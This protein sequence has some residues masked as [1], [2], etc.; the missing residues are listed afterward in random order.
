[1]QRFSPISSVHGPRKTVWLLLI[2]LITYLGQSAQIAGAAETG[3]PTPI[4]NDLAVND[5]VALNQMANDLVADDP[6]AQR[7]DALEQN[8]TRLSDDYRSLQND[9]DDLK[10]SM[11]RFVHPGHGDATMKVGGRIHLDYWAFPASSPGI[12][13]IATAGL[14]DSPQDRIGFRRARFGVK[15]ELLKTM[16]YKIEMEFAAGIRTEFRDLYIG[17]KDLPILRTLLVGNQKR[18]YGLDHLN[19]SRFNVFMERPFIIEAFNQDSRRLGIA[20]YGV[21]E[22]EAWNWRYG[23]YNMRLVQDEGRYTSDHYQLEFAGRLA[24][25][26]WYDESSDGRGYAHWG[27]SG[28][29]ASPD[30]SAPPL[31]LQGGNE[32]EFRTRPEARTRLRWLNTGPIAGADH[33]GLLGAESVLNLGPLQ[34]V[35]EYQNVWLG[36]DPGSGRDLHFHGGYVY[37]SYFLTGEHMPWDRKSGTLARIIPFEN[38]F[39][40]DTCCDGVSKGR[41]AWQIAARWSYAN[42]TDDNIDGGV[43][44]SGT[45]GLNWYLN[46]YTRMQF[47]YIYG[48]IHQHIPVDGFTSGVYQIAG[49][50]FMV[51]F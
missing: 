19:S 2:G 37:V 48:D 34:L 20:S 14:G 26:L 46:A 22:N 29:Y 17:M 31:P 49:M 16:Q 51:D 28:T 36:R 30:G 50:R 10:S 13:E 9:Y 6:I 1:M 35:G 15:G 43:G 12:D 18:P 3:Y 41:G 27:L 23:V 24:N 21:S 8:Y 40:V 4:A 32:A 47:N 42:L 33:Y 45:L 5:Q 7:M 11:T 25:T 38:F 44:Q 39:L